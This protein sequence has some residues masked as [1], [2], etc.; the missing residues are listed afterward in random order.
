MPFEVE[1]GR[2]R[3]FASTIG[4]KN[5]IYFD[6]EAAKRAGHRDLPAPPTFLSNS[7]ELAL[8]NPLGWIA[9]LGGDLTKTTHAEQS[10]TYHKLAYATDQLVFQRRIV[11]VYTKKNGALKFIVKQ[12]DVKRGDETLLEARCVI[13][14]RH[15]EAVK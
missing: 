5:P 9:E 2:P 11:D 8:P 3:F 13:A 15:P 14:L 4:L 10:F 1:R 7:L 12:T 6:V